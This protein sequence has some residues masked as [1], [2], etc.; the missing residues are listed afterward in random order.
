[1]LLVALSALHADCI[2]PSSLLTYD[3]CIPDWY[4]IELIVCDTNTPEQLDLCRPV[5]SDPQV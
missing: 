2:S 3:E 4:L 1:M 5:W